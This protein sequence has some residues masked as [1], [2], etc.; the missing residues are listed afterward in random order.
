MTTTTLV[1]VGAASHAPLFLEVDH[2]HIYPLFLAALLGVA[3]RQEKA[4]LCS[5]CHDR[6]H[7]FIRH[8]VNEGTLGGHRPGVGERKLLDLFWAWWT[9]GGMR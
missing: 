6:Q 7:H 1:C 2:H 9:V 4:I 8:L 3:D 5:G